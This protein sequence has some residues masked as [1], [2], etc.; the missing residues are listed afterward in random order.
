MSLFV[1]VV[2]GYALPVGGGVPLGGA[3][4]L[5]DARGSPIE[6]AKAGFVGLVFDAL[7]DGLFGLAAGWLPT[8]GPSAS[9]GALRD[10]LSTRA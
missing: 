9:K 1:A 10:M 3:G 6:R 2:L 8:D 5:E 7:P 4:S